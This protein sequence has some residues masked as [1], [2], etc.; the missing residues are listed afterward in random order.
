MI[1]KIHDIVL[2]DRRFKVREIS[3]TASIS[4]G[5]VWHSSHECLGM[6]K[7]SRRWVPR[8]LTADH[9]RAHVVA[10]EQ[11]LGIFQRNLK[12]FSLRYVT[13]DETWIH[14]YTPGTKNQLKMWTGP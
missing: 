6:R 10:S 5:R 8:L 9:K 13:F 1:D 4:V 11:C 2:N 14:Y 12:E 7:L 3:E